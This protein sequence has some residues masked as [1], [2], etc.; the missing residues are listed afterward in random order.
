MDCN[1]Y[2][3]C[4]IPID[5]EENNYDDCEKL[6]L[7][8]TFEDAHDFAKKWILFHKEDIIQDEQSGIYVTIDQNGHPSKILLIGE[9][10]LLPINVDIEVQSM[11]IF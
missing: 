5:A 11:Q 3:V 8:D 10:S 1:C 6:G 7:F 4:L 9:V 2:L